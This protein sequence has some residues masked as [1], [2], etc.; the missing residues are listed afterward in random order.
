M[1]GESPDKSEQRKSSGETTPGEHDPRLA[2]LGRTASP[3]A[4]QPT[5][6]FRLP[7][8]RS[9]ESGAQT[10]A[11]ARSE[12]LAGRGRTPGTETGSIE[13]DARLRS[14]VAAWVASADAEPAVGASAE[15]GASAET[16]AIP[17]AAA[18]RTAL[19]PAAAPA[20]PGRD[21]P[22]PDV[23]EADASE[24][25]DGLRDTAPDDSEAGARAGAGAG[26]GGDGG[27]GGDGRS[28]DAADATGDP[29]KG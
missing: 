6:V 12:P 9:A 15:P 18:E 2:M 24:A 22:G 19:L 14:A 8:E 1:A 17:E 7:G 25:A 27:D 26:A 10:G 11:E 20:A 29:V 28:S 23:P 4:D 21:V 5:A 16:T 3:G 13:N